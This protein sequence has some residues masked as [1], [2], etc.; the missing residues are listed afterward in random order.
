MY[1]KVENEFYNGLPVNWKND[2][3]HSPLIKEFLDEI[4]D[5]M[6]S[7]VKNAHSNIRP[8][9]LRFDLKSYPEIE[10]DVKK[11]IEKTVEF[12]KEKNKYFCIYFQQEIIKNDAHYHFIAIVDGKNDYKSYKKFAITI[13]KIWNSINTEF[14]LYTRE[15]KHYYKIWKKCDF[16]A[17]FY[18]ASYLA[19]FKGK[20][21]F[22]QFKRRNHD[23]SKQRNLQPYDQE[24]GF[25]RLPQV[26]A[27]FNIA[28]STLYLG[29]NKGLY[30]KPY[31]LGSRISVWKRSDIYDIINNCSTK[32]H[33]TMLQS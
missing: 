21:S 2:N 9:L 24:Q 26:L 11:F 14:E 15:E 25:L 12:H 17:A 10:R 31:K 28:K 23:G 5:L 1:T 8:V 4:F 16:D 3:K 22:I 29:I 18:A 27:L 13:Q 32:Q 7:S 33:D 20:E 30:P 19:K 6:N